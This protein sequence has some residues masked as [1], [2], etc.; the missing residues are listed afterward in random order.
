MR[1]RGLRPPLELLHLAP[2]HVLH[3][4]TLA[5]H[6]ARLVAYLDRAQQRPIAREQLVQQRVALAHRRPAAAA[7]AAAP[8]SSALGLLGCAQLVDEL[9]HSLGV[10]LNAIQ[11]V[12]LGRVA[13]RLHRE[14]GERVLAVGLELRR[15]LRGALLATLQQLVD[16]LLGQRRTLHLQH[17]VR[18][19]ADQTHQLIRLQVGHGDAEPPLL[20]DEAVEVQL[21]LRT[22]EDLLLE[23]VLDAQPVD[24][25]GAGLADPVRAVLCLQV[26]LRVPIRVIQ[27]DSVGGEQVDAQPARASREHEDEDVRAG[28]VERRHH[29]LA[30][31]SGRAAVEP[32]VLVATIEAIVFEDVEHLGHGGED[33]DAMAALL[34]LPQQL[35][36]HDELAR[37][38]DQVLA[39]DERRAGLGAVKQVRVVTHLA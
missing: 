1:I 9:P 4:L 38:L 28:R 29:L 17:R 22:L 24:G 8:R 37:V 30:L 7:A 31:F 26:S 33:E 6:A 18:S 36:H 32:A 35:V 21:A 5:L 23:R 3:R 15:L 14:V 13:A 2:H 12:E 16:V 19:E 11:L 10:V 27:D 25:H 20:D 34:E 39:L